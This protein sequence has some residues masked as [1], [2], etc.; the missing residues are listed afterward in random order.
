[1]DA[2][3]VA[4]TELAQIIARQSETIAALQAPTPAPMPPDVAARVAAQERVADETE[5]RTYREMHELAKKWQLRALDAESELR[6]LQLRDHRLR[7]Q[8]LRDQRNDSTPPPSGKGLYHFHSLEVPLS[9][10][11][12]LYSRNERLAR[13][14]L[15]EGD[16]L[17]IMR[18]E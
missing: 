3:D 14:Y 17:A 18:E 15:H 10:T 16:A 8:Q 13:I 4:I 9:A 2:R 11:Y 5:Q 6:E 12:A 1:M 7:D